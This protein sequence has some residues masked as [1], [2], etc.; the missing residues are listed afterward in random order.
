MFER[1]EPEKLTNQSFSQEI[2]MSSMT[3]N[4]GYVLVF[5]LKAKAQIKLYNVLVFL[6]EIDGSK[7]HL[8][9]AK[10]KN[11]QRCKRKKNRIYGFVLKSYHSLH[12]L[13]RKVKD[14]IK[15]DLTYFTWLLSHI[16][17]YSLETFVNPLLTIKV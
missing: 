3:L 10:N 13:Y 9:T 1:K 15:F 2:L 6:I 11:Y 5:W 7:Q 17:S 14:E 8:Q 4:V 16:I 12:E